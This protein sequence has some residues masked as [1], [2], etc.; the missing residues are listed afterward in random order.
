M[1]S[2]PEA[3]GNRCG[4]NRMMFDEDNVLLPDQASIRNT[5]GL[6]LLLLL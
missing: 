1:A 3:V 5:L 4:L 2:G 6:C